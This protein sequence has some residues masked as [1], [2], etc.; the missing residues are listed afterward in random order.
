MQSDLQIPIWGGI[1]C[2]INRVGNNFYDQLEMNGFYDSDENI[3]ALVACNIK[4]IRFPILWERHESVKGCVI[5]WSWAA[6]QLNSLKENNIEPIIGLVHHGSGPAFTNLLD[7]NFSELF[8]AYAAEVAEQFPWITYYNPINEPLT[9]A[10]FSGLY[11]L[12]Y[13]HKTN[14]VSFIEILLN[15]LKGIVLAMK[16]IRKINPSAKLIQTEDLSKTY[17]TPILKY[18][19]TFENHRRWLTYDILSGRF[20]STHQLWKYFLRLGIKRETL[21]FFTKNPCEPDILGVNYYVT[22]ERYLDENIKNYSAESVGGNTL[23]SYADVEAVRIELTERNGL[24]LLL[25]EIWKRYHVP[26]AITEVHL[27]CFREEQIRWLKHVYNEASTAKRNGINVFA[28]TSWAMFGSFGWD[29]LL[30]TFP[31]MYEMGAFDMSSGKIRFTALAK[32][33]QSINS[34][35]ISFQNLQPQDGWWNSKRRFFNSSLLKKLKQDINESPL[36]IVGKT[37]TLGRAFSK[38][39]HQ[40]K[41]HHHLLSRNDIDISHFEEVEKIIQEFKP[42]AIIN[43]AGFVDIDKA[44]QDPQACYRDN[45]ISNQNLGVLCKKYGIKLLTFSTD[46]VFDGQALT[47]YTESSDTNPLNV[48]GHSKVL[49]ENFLLN[50]NPSSLIIRTSAFFGPWD[51]HSFIT[52]CM[53]ALHANEMFEAADDT[54]VS[55]TYIPHLVHA[56]LDLLVDDAGGIWHLVNKGETTWYDWAKAT[57]RIT[58]LNEQLILPSRTSGAA[59]RPKYSVLASEKY[60]LM[61]TLEKAME[62]Y[63]TKKY[64][65]IFV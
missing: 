16:E 29:K 64:D 5:N 50:A 63:L 43:A 31:G 44:E 32:L 42:W 36:L 2:S 24:G 48:Y 19:A 13:P 7:K 54:V 28:V 6:G 10:R 46:Q 26:I 37:G 38:I 15:E 8:A 30:T 34:N 47:A 39:C 17:S 1:E 62:E 41:F 3:Q 60:I 21:D 57:A 52:K 33:I 25:E 61:P 55:P 58:D 53:E 27:H 45:D 14:D 51:E 9:T 59:V 23:H 49:A 65:K 11:G 40:R 12:W 22:S 20:T 18:Q 35:N 56:S 4:T